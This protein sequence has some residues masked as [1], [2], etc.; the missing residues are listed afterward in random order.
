MVDDKF[1]SDDGIT[2]VYRSTPHNRPESGH[3]GEVGMSNTEPTAATNQ[4][5]PVVLNKA[6]VLS[7]KRLTLRPPAKRDIAT[8]VRLANNS[9]VAEN[10]GAMPHPYGE[11]DAEHWVYTLA[12][13]GERA[14]TFAVTDRYSDEF[15]GGCSYRPCGVHEGQVSIGYW[16]GEEYWGQGFA[17]EASQTLI[18]FA[19]ENETINTVWVSVRVSNH[20]SR[21]V[22]EKCGFQFAHNGM[23]Q[24]LALDTIVPID[25]YSINRRTWESLHA[26][27]ER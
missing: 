16:L 27:G 2:S 25:Y 19:F 7:T 12:K 1:F 18:D 15:M 21:R 20:Q 22:I 6:V 10:L 8:L 5:A 26:W 14:Q 24:S 17:A 11:I 4:T 9:K 23:A 3:P 13:P